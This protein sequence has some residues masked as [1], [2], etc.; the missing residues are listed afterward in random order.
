[1]IVFVSICLKIWVLETV[2]NIIAFH[3]GKLV[4]SRYNKIVRC[5]SCISMGKF[6]CYQG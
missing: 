2:I 4:F 3:K 1:M 5:S 6:F